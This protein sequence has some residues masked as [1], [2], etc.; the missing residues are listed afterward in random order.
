M[1]GSMR[2]SLILFL[3]MSSTTGI[4]LVLHTT[5]TATRLPIVLYYNNSY[6]IPGGL[7]G[8]QEQKVDT[9]CNK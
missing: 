7:W 2:A 6:F 1:R 5:R 4:A 8:I 3:N 9:Y